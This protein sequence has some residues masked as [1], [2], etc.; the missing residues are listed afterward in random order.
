ML[1]EIWELV[2]HAVMVEVTVTKTFVLEPDVYIGKVSTEVVYPHC[3]E[4]VG[5]GNVL[6]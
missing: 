4:G 1:S 3:P 2:E 5:D 6:L